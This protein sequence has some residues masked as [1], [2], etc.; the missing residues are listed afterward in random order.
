[1]RFSRKISTKYALE[2]RKNGFSTLEAIAL[3][4]AHLAGFD[5]AIAMIKVFIRN[6]KSK[7]VTQIDSEKDLEY[8][9]GFEDG[10]DSI[11]NSVN[12]FDRE[13]YSQE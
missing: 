7:A 12:S 3:A 11:E 10:I 2:Q 4:E 5:T 1:M 8:W 9:K 6:Y 13:A